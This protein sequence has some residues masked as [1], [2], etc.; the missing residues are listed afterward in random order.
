MIQ[1]RG[2]GPDQGAIPSPDWLGLKTDPYP[3]AAA[4]LAGESQTGIPV[5]H[6]GKTGFKAE[7]AETSCQFGETDGASAGREPDIPG[8]WILWPIRCLTVGPF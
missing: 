3:A 8:R 1:Q 7:T 6:P 4:R 5:I 2:A